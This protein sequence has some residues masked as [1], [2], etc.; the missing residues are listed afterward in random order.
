MNEQ[1]KQAYLE[2]DMAR[3]MLVLADELR[4]LALENERLSHEKYERLL[5][6]LHRVEAERR[7]AHG[8]A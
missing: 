7:R 2:W 1:I 6:R 3:R 8:Q 4:S 5:G